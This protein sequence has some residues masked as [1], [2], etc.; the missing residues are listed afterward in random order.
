MTSA[1]R[2]QLDSADTKAILDSPEAFEIIDALLKLY[3]LQ[4]R[5]ELRQQETIQSLLDRIYGRK[6][7][8]SKYHPNQTLLLPELLEE[9]IDEAVDA[10]EAPADESGNA[11]PNDAVDEHDNSSNGE[12]PKRRGGH[13][14]SKLP[15]HIERRVVERID[16]DTPNCDSCDAER[17]I[18]RI[19]KSERMNY[20]P[21]KVVADVTEIVIR[22]PLPCDCDDDA[23]KI[24]RPELPSRPIDRGM[25]GVELLLSI[26]IGKFVYHLPHY[27]QVT[28]TLKDAG[29]NLSKQT[30]WNWTRRTADLL[31]PLWELM[32]E[33]LLTLDRLAADETTTPMVDRR[34]P[35]SQTKTTYLWQ[36]RGFD[37]GAAPYTVFDFAL[38]RAHTAPAAFLKG[39]ADA[40]RPGCC[41]ACDCSSNSSG[42]TSC[43]NR[44][45][46]RRSPT[47]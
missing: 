33:K 28:K 9:L 7:E 20:I 47:P 12:K 1:E 31:E 24:V 19:E 40:N 44:K 13:G 46:A 22:G 21:A 29:I 5:T 41:S 43:R 26:V 36:Y 2:Y 37:G 4:C 23:P 27:R 35:G 14:R 25:P 34:R 15:E 38:T 10:S 6:S 17:P 18:I 45:S 42:R 8:K 30:V 32:H 39:F 16:V 11:E 3:R